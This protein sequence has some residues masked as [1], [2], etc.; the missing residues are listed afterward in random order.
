MAHDRAGF[1]AT[2]DPAQTGFYAAQKRLYDRLQDVDLA[3][4]SYQV[5]GSGPYVAGSVAGCRPLHRRG[6]SMT[7]CSST[8]GRERA[9]SRPSR[10]RPPPGRTT[11][12]RRRRPRGHLPAYR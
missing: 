10:H 6:P 11:P 1:L 9:S 8:T 3:S 12:R 7:G 4:W 2:V 5:E